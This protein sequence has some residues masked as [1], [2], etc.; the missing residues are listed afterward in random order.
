MSV[1]PG[2]IVLIEQLL[3]KYGHLVDAAAWDR[4]DELFTPD[5]VLDYT[6][7]SAP[8][9]CHGVAEVVAYFK[10]VNHPSAHHVANV[11]VD[12]VDGEVRVKSK[13]FVPFTRPS[14]TTKRWLGGDYDDVVVRT[15]DGWRFA[16][17]VCTVRWQY[18][19]GADE[20]GDDRR[21][22]TF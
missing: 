1:E 20:R 10:S 18:V 12:E 19:P 11:W 17:R 6:P 3:A 9:V 21:S 16:R 22:R 5:V 4:F 13:F 2:D 8:S 14:H 15:P 7:A